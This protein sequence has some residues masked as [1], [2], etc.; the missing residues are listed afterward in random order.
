V[1]RLV[2]AHAFVDP[3]GREHVRVLRCQPP[4]LHYAHTHKRPR[5]RKLVP[6][7]PRVLVVTSS[8]ELDAALTVQVTTDE[9]H[10]SH[11]LT[12]AARETSVPRILQDLQPPL[13][14]QV[15]S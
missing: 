12:A 4:D 8:W 1:E 9:L 6:P 2:A 15:V 10:L 13:P 11:A 3:P 5:L 14:P 7:D